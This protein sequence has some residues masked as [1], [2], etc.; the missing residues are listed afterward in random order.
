MAKW[1]NF[2]VS[3]KWSNPKSVSEAD[4]IQITFFTI[5]K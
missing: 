3:T 5:D 2:R 4:E 1:I